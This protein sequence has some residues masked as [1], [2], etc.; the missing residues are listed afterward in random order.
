MDTI[1]EYRNTIFHESNQLILRKKKQ[2][3]LNLCSLYNQKF[4]HF[5]LAV[6]QET[7]THD[8]H[9]I[10]KIVQTIHEIYAC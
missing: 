10:T 5:M 7:S 3:S 8:G 4:I 2:S 6:C 1:P 9:R